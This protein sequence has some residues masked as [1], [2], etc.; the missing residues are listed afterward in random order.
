MTKFEL[1]RLVETPGVH[2]RSNENEAF[3]RFKTISLGK[4]IDG[5]WGSTPK[6]D[7]ELNGLALKPNDGTRIFASYTDENNPDWTLWIITEG[8]HSATVIMFPNEF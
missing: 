6:D 3:W 7:L 8:D 1:G 2:A 5:D 4:Y